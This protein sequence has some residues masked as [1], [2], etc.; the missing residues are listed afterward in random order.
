MRS[1]IGWVI[2]GFGVV[3]A[4]AFVRS[5]TRRYRRLF[6][7]EHFFEIAHACPRLKA[8][9]LERPIIDEQDMPRT[10]DDPRAL[11]TRAGLAIVYTVRPQESE[12]VHH[13]S[14][15]V[16]GGYTAHAV[17]ATFVVFLAKLIGLPI[18]KSSFVIGSS[19]VH[20]LDASLSPEDH[21]RVVAHAVP[22]VS[23]SNY[24]EVRRNVQDAIRRV[25]WVRLGP[26]NPAPRSAG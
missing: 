6:A 3:S 18:E 1:M 9:A 15:S 11:V 13:C 21:A 14:V 22:E 4:V 5:R 20:H 10:P 25:T 17:G 16:P 26:G 23:E 8:A 2:V 19:T 12:L 24:P 7:D